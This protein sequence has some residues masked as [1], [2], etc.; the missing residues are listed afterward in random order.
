LKDLK[1]SR[2]DVLSHCKVDE[3]ERSHRIWQRDPLAVL[4]DNQ[5]K[6]EQKI[7]R[8]AFRYMHNNPLHECWNLA[9]HPE[10][11][12]WSSASFY[13][14]GVDEFGILTHYMERF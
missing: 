14:T 10:N 13:E 6:V 4:V 1:A 9:D 3:P 5:Q 7:V 2:P 8:A 11:Y 12:R